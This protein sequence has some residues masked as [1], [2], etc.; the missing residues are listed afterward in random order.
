MFKTIPMFREQH[1]Y[2]GEGP[3]HNGAHDLANLLNNLHTF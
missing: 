1:V 2:D 3:T